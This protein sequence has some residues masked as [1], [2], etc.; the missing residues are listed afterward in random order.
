[1][2][3]AT[4]SKPFTQQEAIPEAGIER[5]VE[6]MESGGLYRYNLRANEDSKAS[7]LEMEYTKWQGTDYCLP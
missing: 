3:Q 1:M 7:Y 2:A 4:F 5:A 6:I